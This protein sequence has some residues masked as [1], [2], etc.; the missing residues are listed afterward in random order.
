MKRDSVFELK[1]EVESLLRHEAERL[2]GPQAEAYINPRVEGRLAVGYSQRSANDYQLELR[3][4]RPNG[5]AFRLAEQIREERARG[6]A[7]IE[8]VAVVEIPTRSG[9]DKAGQKPLQKTKRPLHIGLSIGHP[10]GGSG[11]LG[12]FVADDNA[13][14][15]LSANHVLSLFGQAD[16]KDRIYQPG[17]T[18]LSRSVRSAG[19]PG[20][21]KVA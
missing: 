4:Q 2:A 8:V 7:N 1:A 5:Q 17:S 13:V 20:S 11:T 6:E 21:P 9:V 12:G 14:Y 18:D 16:D 3:V 10:S 19:P 15:L